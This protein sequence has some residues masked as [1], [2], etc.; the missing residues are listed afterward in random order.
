MF[1]L[2]L[3]SSGHTVLL[4]K[5]HVDRAETHAQS[6]VLSLSLSHTH[7]Q[8]HATISTRPS[9]A[10]ASRHTDTHRHTMPSSE[11]SGWSGAG[12]KAVKALAAGSSPSPPL[13]GRPASRPLTML[14]SSP[15]CVL[16]VST[17][18][19]DTQTEATGK[20][21]QEM[22]PLLLEKSG[23]GV[24]GTV[25]GAEATEEAKATHKIPSARA[26]SFG[27]TL[28][29]VKGQPENTRQAH[30]N[31]LLCEGVE[32]VCAD[33]GTDAAT[34]SGGRVS[35]DSTEV[36]GG[37]VAKSE[38]RDDGGGGA[39]LTFLEDKLR[40]RP[41]KEVCFHLC[42]WLLFLCC[43]H[44]PAPSPPHSLFPS[45]S[46]SPPLSLPPCL[47]GA[48]S[49]ARSSVRASYA[50][51]SSACS[52]PRKKISR[53]H[54]CIHPCKHR[55]AHTKCAGA[56][57][58][59]YPQEFFDRGDANHPSS[60]AAAAD[61]ADGQFAGAQVAFAPAHAAACAPQDYPGGNR[62]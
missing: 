36:L 41:S 14:T 22:A 61:A 21:C 16:H 6:H 57:P 49:L 29:G 55:H 39:L 42:L 4:Q 45:P 44:P 8:V 47:S 52:K 30:R 1:V 43:P 60:T 46:L 7:T 59:K 50:E 32:T 5:W 10:S 27:E 11:P 9:S 12:Q 31:V 3:L 51:E 35:V 40:N 17:S 48:R 23:R 54:I 38:G 18:D 15:A 28:R 24:G 58:A 26:H 56:L 33:A 19:M 20:D 2:P 62:T 25:K 53:V 37:P 34:Q 13:K